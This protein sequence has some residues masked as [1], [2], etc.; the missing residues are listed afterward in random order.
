VALGLI[1]QDLNRTLTDED[2]DRIV[3]AVVADLAQHLDAKIR[4]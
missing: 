3:T 1:L 4:E 2:A